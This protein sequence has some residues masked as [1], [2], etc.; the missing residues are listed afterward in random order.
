MV[1]ASK[2]GPLRRPSSADRSPEPGADAASSMP[3]GYLLRLARVVGYGLLLISFIDF[4]YVLIPAKFMD[5]VWEYQFVGDLIR[6][7]PV[8]LL[9]LVLVFGGDG[10]ERQPIEWPLLKFFSWLTLV[11]SIILFLLIPL[12]VANTLRIHQFNNEQID[13]QM[14]QQR[15][16]LDANLAELQQATPQQLQSLLSS[17][18]TAL[19][20]EDARAQILENVNKAKDQADTRA[21]Q[22]RANVKQNLIKNSL[23]LVSESFLGSFLFLYAWLISG[24]ARRGE[25]VLTTDNRPQ[26]N[27]ATVFG[28]R[29]SRLLGRRPKRM[30]HRIR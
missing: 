3:L 4:L 2:F 12:T 18:N 21:D 22:A 15:Q 14:N 9:A 20:P 1:S 25:G 17:A 11:L 5:P 16:Q 29:V 23:K 7:V 19:S 30:Q 10:T 27:P 24:W 6:L 28:R 8:P 26:V 13:T